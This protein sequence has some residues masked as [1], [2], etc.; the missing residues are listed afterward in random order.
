VGVSGE[1]TN[2]TTP[3]L[4]VVYKALGS[5]PEDLGYHMTNPSDFLRTFQVR[6]SSPKN[7][8]TVNIMNVHWV[9][10]CDTPAMSLS[11]SNL[12]YLVELVGVC[13]EEGSFRI[14]YSLQTS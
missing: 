5:N 3:L 9:C 2:C 14:D 7:I 8:P 1:I 10:Q 11:R 4:Y 6:R 13:T 12:H